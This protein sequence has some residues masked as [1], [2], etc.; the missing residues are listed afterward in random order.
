MNKEEVYYSLLILLYICYFGC[1]IMAVFRKK[2]INYVYTIGIWLVCLGFH[3][4]SMAITNF[5][6]LKSLIVGIFFY[7]L[8]V[9][10][11]NGRVTSE[12]FLIISKW[13][14]Y[15]ENFRELMHSIWKS[16]YE[17]LLWRH[18]FIVLSKKWWL[19][20]ILSFLFAISH[21]KRNKEIIELFIFSL[22][23]YCIV[24]VSYTDIRAHETSQDRV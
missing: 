20:C 21:I 2:Y 18:S 3:W 4:F 7:A 17:E 19:V 12:C 6:P 11:V 5:Y 22:I 16:S 15:K 23:E 24:T 14:L 10:V 9:F 1:I 13:R 8:S